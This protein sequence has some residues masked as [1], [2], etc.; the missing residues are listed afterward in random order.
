[1]QGLVLVDRGKLA[2]SLLGEPALGDV[3]DHRDRELRIAV[4]VTHERDRHM[5]PDDLAVRSF[6]ADVVGCELAG[7][8]QQ[9]LQV[10]LLVSAVFLGY[11]GRELLAL[12]SFLRTVEELAERRIRIVDAKLRV[13]R[14]DPDRRT[15]VDS[16]E[17]RQYLDALAALLEFGSITERRRQ[18]Q[19]EQ[20]EALGEPLVEGSRSDGD[21]AEQTNHRAVVLER[22]DEHRRQFLAKQWS[23]VRVLADEAVRLDELLRATLLDRL[24]EGAVRLRLHASAVVANEVTAGAGADEVVVLAQQDDGAI[25][26]GE[27]ARALGDDR[28]NSLH[29]EFGLG[30]LPLNSND[31]VQPLVRHK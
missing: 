17:L 4:E 26:S 28:A 12:E 30:N 13:N 11:E 20:L 22:H 10:A 8:A 29:A 15:R 24:A 6:E 5:C 19:R 31:R 27:F 16:V 23:E 18:N 3:L 7:A 25:G 21:D 9:R 1:M 14:R 2:R